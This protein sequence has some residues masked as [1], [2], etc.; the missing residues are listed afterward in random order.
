[1]KRNPINTES[2]T[3]QKRFL[4]IIM[5]LLHVAQ[6]QI[7]EGQGLSFDCLLNK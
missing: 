2:S 5:S 4:L 1:M 6:T 3:P 7:S